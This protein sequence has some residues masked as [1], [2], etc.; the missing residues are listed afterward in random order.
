MECN[1]TSALVEKPVKIQRKISAIPI[2]SYDINTDLAWFQVSA[3]VWMRYSLFWDVTRR[4]FLVT[5]VSGQPIGLTFKGPETSVTEYQSTLRNI[6][7]ERKCNAY[8]VLH[9]GSLDLE[10]LRCGDFTEYGR[11]EYGNF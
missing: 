2:S 10:T 9:I 4:S 5:G 11:C 1:V 8:P 7:E 3:E 6:P